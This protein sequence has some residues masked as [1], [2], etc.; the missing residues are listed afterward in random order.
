M[1]NDR[2]PSD[3]RPRTGSGDGA[4]NDGAA[5][6]DATTPREEA[7]VAGK[8]TIEVVT[9]DRAPP[10]PRRQPRQPHQIVQLGRPKPK[11]YVN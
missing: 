1:S 3:D 2:V 4:A 8:S 5:N 9:P 6:D 11:S 10:A 7:P